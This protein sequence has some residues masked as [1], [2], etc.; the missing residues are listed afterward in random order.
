M[1]TSSFDLL[2]GGLVKNQTT[3]TIARPVVKCE[4]GKL[5]RFVNSGEVPERLNDLEALEPEPAG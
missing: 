5:A 2:Y 4:L 1:Y 3:T